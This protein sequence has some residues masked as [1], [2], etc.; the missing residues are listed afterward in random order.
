[1]LCCKMLKFTF[2]AVVPE[3]TLGLRTQPIRPPTPLQNIQLPVTPN[4]NGNPESTTKFP[5]YSVGLVK[6]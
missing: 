4:F 3:L 1:M 6:I 5:N 2:S